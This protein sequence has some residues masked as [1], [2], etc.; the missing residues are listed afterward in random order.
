MPPHRRFHPT[1]AAACRRRTAPPDPVRLS[2]PPRPVRLRSGLC[3]PAPHAAALPRS[4]PPHAAARSPLGHRPDLSPPAA[5]PTLSG[6]HSHPMAPKKPSGNFGV[7]FSDAGR[8]WWLGTYPTADEAARAYDVAVW[9]A[10]RPKTDLNFPEIETRAVAEWLVPQ[11]IRMEE[12]A[13]KKKK[14]P[15][16]FYLKHDAEE[17]KKEKVKKEDEAGPSTAIPIELS[18]E[19]EEF[20]GLSDDS[21]ESYWMPSDDE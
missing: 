1:W 12:M 20:W 17:K 19:D 4:P 8:R 21:E 7:E 14:R 3:T 6:H 11:G 15:A 9:R 13:A 18:S 5:S 2:A 16:E 10:V